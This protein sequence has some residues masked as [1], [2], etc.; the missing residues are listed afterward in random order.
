MF[1]TKSNREVHMIVH[2]KAGEVAMPVMQ[3]QYSMPSIPVNGT[4][5]IH[6]PP[7]ALN[8]MPGATV[9]VGQQQQD[10][11]PTNHVDVQGG[12]PTQQQVQMPLGQNAAVVHHPPLASAENHR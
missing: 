4:T 12:N 8:G 11:M 9:G 6:H 1:G 5:M 7:I 2:P 3:K 10:F